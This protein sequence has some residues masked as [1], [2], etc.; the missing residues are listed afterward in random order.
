M[1]KVLC[2]LTLLTFVTQGYSSKSVTKYN[3]YAIKAIN[4]KAEMF[5]SHVKSNK[6]N[7]VSPQ[8]KK[9]KYYKNSNGQRVQSPTRY[10]YVPSGATAECM[11]GTY[12]FSRNRRGTCSHHG[13]VKKWL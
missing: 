6:I 8:Q 7:Y 11:D 1:K 2:I 4:F 3:I 9:K 13:G 5:I 12:S 10:N